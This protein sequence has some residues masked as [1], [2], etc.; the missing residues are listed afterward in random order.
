MAC[1]LNMMVS[2]MKSS[3][4]TDKEYSRKNRDYDDQDRRH[5]SNNGKW[6]ILGK[7]TKNIAYNKYHTGNQ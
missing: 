7:W 6:F 5:L 3:S 1:I 4:R 2:S